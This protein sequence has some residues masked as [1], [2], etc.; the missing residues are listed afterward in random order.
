MNIFKKFDADKTGSLD[1]HEFAELIRNVTPGLKDHEIQ[2]LFI[3]FDLNDDK[4]INF[5]EFK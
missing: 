1:V 3:N 5:Q 2:C 4:L